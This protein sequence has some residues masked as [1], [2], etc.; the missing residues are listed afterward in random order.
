[1]QIHIQRDGQAQGPYSLEV[2][3]S[4]LAA[5]AL[6]PDTLAWHQGA[7]DWRPLSDI[8]GIASG[9]PPPLPG[10]TTPAGTLTQTSGLAITSMVFGMLA[11]FTIGLTAIPAVICGH[12]SRASIKK[13]AGTVTG[14]GFAL[15]GLILGYAG[16]AIMA[17][18]FLAGIMVPVILSTQ[19]NAARQEAIANAKSIGFA[20]LSFEQDYGMLPCDASAGEVKN[21]NRRTTLNLGHTSSNDYFRQLIAAGCVDTEKSFYARIAACSKPDNRMD[22]DDALTKGECGFSY[23]IGTKSKSSPPQPMVVTPL[24]PGTDRFDPK[25]FGGK[26]IIVWTD[27]SSQFMP[28]DSNGHV[29]HQGENL[30]EPS[31]PVWQGKAPHIAWPE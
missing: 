16:F 18:A 27:G 21:R 31:H 8:P 5:G 17:L 2:V 10:L 28:I 26:A 24:I 25:P 1:M 15:T 6:Q 12:I 9:S 20:L 19:K 22:D 13:S 30:L 14:D 11:F 7:P 29:L 23:I 4:Q 3:R